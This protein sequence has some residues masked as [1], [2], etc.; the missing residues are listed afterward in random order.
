MA[1]FHSGRRTIVL[2]ILRKDRL[3]IYGITTDLLICSRVMPPG[4]RILGGRTRGQARGPGRPYSCRRQVS[5]IFPSKSACTCLA[6]VGLGRRIFAEGA[7]MGIA[8]KYKGIGDRMIGRSDS[9]SIKACRDLRRNLSELRSTSGDPAVEPRGVCCRDIAAEQFESGYICHMCDRII[10][11]TPFALKI[12]C[13][14]AL[15]IALRRLYRLEKATRPL[16]A[17]SQLLFGYAC[18]LSVC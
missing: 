8:S 3:I 9:Y 6:S 18:L 7:A 2:G 11:R 4:R 5:S 15:S 13:T 16:N 10:L 12:R 17:V 1:V 14:A